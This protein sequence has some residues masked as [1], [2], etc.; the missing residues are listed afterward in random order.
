MKRLTI[1]IFTLALLGTAP[2]AHSYQADVIDISG[3]KYL[4]AVKEALAKAQKSIFLVMYFVNFDPQTVKSP[5][6]ELVTELVNA[7]KRGVK[8][9]VILDQ[10]V[11]FNQTGRMGPKEDKNEAI[12]IYLKQQGIPAYFDNL[13][14]TT[15]SKAIVIDEETVIVGSSNWT[16][17]AIRTNREASCLARSPE[18]A[19]QFLSGFSAITLD[20]EASA[21]TEAKRPPVR[22]SDVFIK[23][24]SLAPRMITKRDETAFDLYLLLLRLYDG[25]PEARVDIDFKSIIQ[26][27]GMDKKYSYTSSYDILTDAL[28]RLDQRY[29]LIRRITQHPKPPYCLLLDYPSE[30]PYK[31]A[32]FAYCSVPDEYWQYGWNKR[33][34]YPEKYFLLINLRKSALNRGKIWSDYLQGI[35]EEFNLH[36]ST[37][38]RGTMGLRKLNIIEA[39]YPPYPEDGSFTHRSP[40]SFWFLGLYSPEALQNEKDKL[41]GHY[42]KKQFDQAETYARIVF[43][44][45]DIQV[46]EDILN[47]ITQFGAKE[48]REAFRKVASRNA[49]NPK[50]SY[51]YVVG[52][53]QT[54]A[55]RNN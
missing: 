3:R 26:T 25:N 44:D 6:T 55:G 5:V 49:A 51:R 50:R 34:S 20:H 54:E 43:K 23:D 15:H 47:K 2:T 19:A 30:Q 29:N 42:G 17:S 14:I 11:S 35:M 53:L 31:P 36:R 46:I 28:I 52:I 27:L 21:S 7:H 10:N 12:F 40:M 13:F 9:T 45:N 39:E 33:L 48:V 41:A 16:E 4:P 1:F 24:P 8:V 22:V 32:Q 38:I 37:V 18:L